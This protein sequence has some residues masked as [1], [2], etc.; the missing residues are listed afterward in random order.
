[1]K[2]IRWIVLV[3]VFVLSGVLMVLNLQPYLEISRKLL[4]IITTVPLLGFLSIL[5]VVGGLISL[6]SRI[7]ADVFGVALWGIIQLVE[8]LPQW[9]RGDLTVL[10]SLIRGIEAIA[11]HAVKSGD[12]ETVAELKEEYNRAPRKW[13][14]RAGTLAIIAYCVDFLLCALRF[15]PYRGG[16]TAF[17]EDIQIGVSSLDSVDWG[18]LGSMLATMFGFELTLLFAC[19]M[20]QGLTYFSRRKQDGEPYYEAPPA[21]SDEPRRGVRRRVR[22]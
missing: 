3:L 5:P 20:A 7:I 4:D 14:K 17:W 16:F 18:N 2:T 9:M 19:W 10:N 21:D 22:A 8:I 15:P 6:V 11:P 13:L 1:M 12:S